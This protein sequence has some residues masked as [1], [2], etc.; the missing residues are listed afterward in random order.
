MSSCVSPL[1]DRHRLLAWVSQTLPRLRPADCQLDRLIPRKNGFDLR[2]D[3]TGQG[4][5]RAEHFRIVPAGAGPEP[6]LALGRWRLVHCDPMRDP[7]LPMADAV[8]RGTL[9]EIGRLLA[10]Q[11]TGWS[12][13]AYTPGRRAVIAYRCA[14]GSTHF[15][16]LYRHGQAPTVLRTVNR[17]R[18]AGL[19]HVLAE[20]VGCLYEAL[21]VWRGVE[22]RPLWLDFP[23]DAY[24]NGLRMAAAALRQL[25][26]AADPPDVAGA[27]R[28]THSDE[29]GVAV[30]Y[31]QRV[32][33]LLGRPP[34]RLQLIC[35]ELQETIGEL[36]TFEDRNLHL[37]F[38]DNQVLLTSRGAVILDLDR[39]TCGD[40][41]V[42][43][44]NF[45]AHIDFRAAYEGSNVDVD[46]YAGEFLSSYGPVGGVGP[47]RRVAF[48]HA[49][50]LVRNCC[51]YVLVPPRFRAL[52]AAARRTLD[53]LRCLND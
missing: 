27:D 11:V 9:D 29:L 45:L 35:D 32:T 49:V 38:H 16:K 10:T 5:A 4:A 43:V 42:D 51:L 31:L 44:G 3:I 18:S 21:I 12:V 48:G 15:G 1:F 34:A 46:P 8:S 41:A 52:A 13:R 25:H 20:P 50:S 37:D 17:L 53:R 47:R 14:D 33:E 39:L 36:G 19:A 30:R 23:T 7:E 6:S 24:R 2:I 40:P 22:G 28:H 26:E